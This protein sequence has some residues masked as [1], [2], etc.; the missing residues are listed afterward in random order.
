MFYF[1]I[2]Y[3]TLSNQ[4]KQHDHTV[5]RGVFWVYGDSLSYYFYM[6]VNNPMRRLCS[7]VFKECNNTYNWIYPKTLYELVSIYCLLGNYWKSYFVRVNSNCSRVCLWKSTFIGLAKALQLLKVFQQ[8]CIVIR[9]SSFL[10]FIG[11]RAYHVTTWPR[12]L[13]NDRL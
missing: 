11:P 4:R 2:D 5:G 13:P 1:L 9:W 8:T 12:E 7:S 3:T 6:S 10:L